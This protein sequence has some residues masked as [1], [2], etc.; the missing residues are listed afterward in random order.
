M[1]RFQKQKTWCVR[2]LS[3]AAHNSLGAKHSAL[4]THCPVRVGWDRGSAQNRLTLGFKRR[5]QS[6]LTPRRRS[7]AH[8][9]RTERRCCCETEVCGSSWSRTGCASS[10]RSVPE[11]SDTFPLLCCSCGVDSWRTF[12]GGNGGAPSSESRRVL[13]SVPQRVRGL[14]ERAVDRGGAVAECFCGGGDLEDGAVQGAPERGGSTQLRVSQ[15]VGP[16]LSLYPSG[17]TSAPSRAI[18]LLPVP[19]LDTDSKGSLLCYFYNVFK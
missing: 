5:N 19:Q 8:T 10:P 18:V 12:E 1:N 11:L 3:E 2:F 15:E 9:S 17:V 4:R 6:G 16:A 14:Q 13:H 7:T